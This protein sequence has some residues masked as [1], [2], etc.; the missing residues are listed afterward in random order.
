M[1]REIDLDEYRAQ[2]GREVGVSQWLPVDQKMIDAYAE[3]SGDHQFIHV[4][5]VRA[6]ETPFGGTIAHGLLVLSLLSSMSYEA[7]PAIRGSAMGINY[8]FDRVR[9]VTPVPVNAR[10][11]ARFVLAELTQRSADQVQTRYAVTMEREG[12]DKP[13]MI[14]DWLTLTVLK[15]A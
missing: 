11:R 7:L 4:D 12:A 15:P 8:G 2:V 6:A 5:P 9:F 3:L 13:A 10:L 1:S 14:A